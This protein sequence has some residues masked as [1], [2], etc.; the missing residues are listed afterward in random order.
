MQIPEKRK[1]KNSIRVIQIIVD[2]K[3]KTQLD[4]IFIK[5]NIVI[6]KSRKNVNNCEIWR[7]IFYVL[8]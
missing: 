7:E 4:R 8:I 6:T 2:E 3:K 1:I 5:Y